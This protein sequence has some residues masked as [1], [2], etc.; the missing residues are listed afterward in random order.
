MV[1]L[2]ERE[3]DHSP[4]WSDEVKNARIYTLRSL[5]IVDITLK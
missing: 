2:P 3:A 5:L 4:P 1:K